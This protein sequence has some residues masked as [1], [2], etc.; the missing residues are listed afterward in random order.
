VPVILKLQM[1]ADRAEIIAD[2]KPARW[3]YA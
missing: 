2:V 3:L 1:L